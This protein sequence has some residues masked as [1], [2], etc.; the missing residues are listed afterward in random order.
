MRINLTPQQ[1]AA[2][3][4]VAETL[5]FGEAAI[6]LGMSQPALS[7]TIRH[8]EE[9][10]GERLF[11]R[12]TRN[13]ALTPAGRELEPIARRIVNEFESDVSDL[14]R[15]ITGRRGRIAVAALPSMAAVLLPSAIVR[16]RQQR[17]DVDFDIRD[18]ISGGVL[19]AVGEGLSEIGLTARPGPD[20]AIAYEPLLGD[21][22]GLV[23]RADDPLARRSYA[24]WTVFAERP[25]IA[26]S[27]GSSVRT[28]TDSAFLECGLQVAPLFSCVFLA[29]ARAMVF[30]GLGIAALPALTVPLMAEAGLVWRPL[31]DPV[32]HR[33]LGL[34]RRAGAT[35]SP[36]TRDFIDVLRVEI[37]RRE[38]DV[39][40]GVGIRSETPSG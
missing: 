3:L 7:R 5:N 37:R 4:R 16:F 29:T 14:A 11:D 13:V 26:M 17:P 36:A 12:D 39:R 24:S 28:M 30:N 8:V 22:F 32:R 1:L 27:Q 33:S 9:T 10:L 34:V 25:F 19:D 35:L 21:D 2:F 6:R 31:V 38:A 20:R 18:A 15:F 23:C 40:L